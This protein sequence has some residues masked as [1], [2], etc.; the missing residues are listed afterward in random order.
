MLTRN[1]AIEKLFCEGDFNVRVT[2]FNPKPY[3]D[4]YLRKL[5]WIE[6]I[7]D[8]IGG[9]LSSK[10]RYKL[11][12]RTSDGKAIFS[13]ILEGTNIAKLLNCLLI[14]PM[15]VRIE[16]NESNS[17]SKPKVWIFV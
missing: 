3:S 11:V 4:E 8:S 13:G 12:I 7:R 17:P 10:T 5:G 6:T 16:V 1:C 15:P 2:V 14:E 9:N